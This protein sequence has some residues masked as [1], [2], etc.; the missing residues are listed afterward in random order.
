MT[1]VAMAACYAITIVTD[2]PLI[3]LHQEAEFPLEWSGD[4]E[5]PPETLDDLRLRVE[6]RE[7]AQD[8]RVIDDDGTYRL[9]LVG[10]LPDG[11]ANEVAEL[12]DAAG[13]NRTAFETRRVFLREEIVREA[14]PLLLSIQGVV[15]LDLVN[16]L[17]KRNIAA[18][19]ALEVNPGE[20]TTVPYGGTRFF[21]IGGLTIRW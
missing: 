6:D 4:G 11:F 7:L 16:A 10:A 2:I 13:F 14:G 3:P 18:T 5:P 21:P 17:N 9:V 8:V 19:Y 12:L 1:L 20:F 15:F